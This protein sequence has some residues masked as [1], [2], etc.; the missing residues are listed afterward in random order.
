MVVQAGGSASQYPALLNKDIMII[1]LVAVIATYSVGMYFLYNHWRNTPPDAF[2]DESEEQPT[3]T[4]KNRLDVSQPTE[5]N[6]AHLLMR[7]R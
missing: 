6:T 7:F 4:R 1:L 2:F 5:R 3:P